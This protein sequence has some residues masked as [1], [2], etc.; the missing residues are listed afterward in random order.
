MGQFVA[1]TTVFD[2]LEN[3]NSKESNRMSAGQHQCTVYCGLFCAK[4]RL[5]SFSVADKM[6]CIRPMWAIN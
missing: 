4:W 3:V 6:G 5:L 2:E 1:A